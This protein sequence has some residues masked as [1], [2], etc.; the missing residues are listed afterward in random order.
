MLIHTTFSIDSITV[1]SNLFSF[2][3]ENNV[4]NLDRKFTDHLADPGMLRK[5]SYA[6]LKSIRVEGDQSLSAAL[7]FKM[8]TMM[9]DDCQGFFICKSCWG[10][11]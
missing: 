2:G 3:D 7:K 5:G 1:L 8:R 10:I 9:T 4:S 6:A 11:Y